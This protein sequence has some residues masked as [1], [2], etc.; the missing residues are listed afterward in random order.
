MY[1]LNKLPF[2]SIEMMHWLIS[3][4]DI[5]TLPAKISI[6][7]LAIRPLT[8]SPM[9]PPRR[10]YPLPVDRARLLKR[11]QRMR[12][13]DRLTRTST[14]DASVSYAARNIDADRISRHACAQVPER[15]RCRRQAASGGTFRCFGP[16]V[17]ALR[18]KSAPAAQNDGAA[19][20]FFI[21]RVYGL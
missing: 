7:R 12:P 15:L 1:G 14:H 20:I 21:F 17:S 13:D 9:P 5:Y 3:R 16:R 6:F 4:P 19:L 11:F 8:C 2:I 18:Y 10:L